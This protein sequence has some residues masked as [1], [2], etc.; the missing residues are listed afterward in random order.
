M[1]TP[2]KNE[3]WARHTNEG[4]DFCRSRRGWLGDVFIFIIIIII[5]IKRKNPNL[6]RHEASSDTLLSLTYH[7]DHKVSDCHVAVT[8]IHVKSL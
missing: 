2:T 4:G 1:L 5:T 7:N 8:L 6:P 3:V